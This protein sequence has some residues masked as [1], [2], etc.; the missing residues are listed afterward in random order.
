MKPIIFS[1]DG[2]SVFLD[3]GDGKADWVRLQRCKNLTTVDTGKLSEFE[4]ALY[5]AGYHLDRKPFD[6]GEVWAWVSLTFFATSFLWAIMLSFFGC[7]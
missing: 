1:S 4:L 3:R 7:G 2:D 5:E 6:W